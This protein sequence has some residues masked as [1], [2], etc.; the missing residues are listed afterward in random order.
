MRNSLKTRQGRCSLA[1]LL[2]TQTFIS[3]FCALINNK[4]MNTAIKIDNVSGIPMLLYDMTLYDPED[5][6][7][8][9]GQSYIL[10]WVCVALFLSLVF[11]NLSLAGTETLDKWSRTSIPRSWIR[12]ISWWFDSLMNIQDQAAHPQ[13]IAYAACMVSCHGS[14]S[15]HLLVSFLGA[16]Q[17]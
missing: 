6:E 15:L 2:I 4:D 5:R 17:S 13:L 16:F 10:I 11:D 9:W 7:A 8:G 3:R 14:F 12:E 1:L